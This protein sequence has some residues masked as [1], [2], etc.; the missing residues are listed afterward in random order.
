MH[1]RH[2]RIQ[3][4]TTS[5]AGIRAGENN[6]HRLPEQQNAQW[7]GDESGAERLVRLPLRGQHWLGRNLC[8]TPLQFPVELLSVNR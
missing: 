2:G 5:L 6:L 1:R 8:I 4:E 3:D 7:L